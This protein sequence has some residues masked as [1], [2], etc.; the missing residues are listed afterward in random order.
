VR[1]RGEARAMELL[2]RKPDRVFLPRLPMMDCRTAGSRERNRK[3][4][5]RYRNV[6]HRGEARAMGGAI[7]FLRCA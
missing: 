1:H 2:A 5:R 6:R 7:G 4:G 3:M